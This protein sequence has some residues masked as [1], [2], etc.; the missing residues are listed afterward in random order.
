MQTGVESKSS[1]RSSLDNGFILAPYTAPII[2]LAKSKIGSNKTTV[3]YSSKGTPKALV[4]DGATLV[5]ALQDSL[6]G[7]LL[8]VTKYC[9]SVICC[10][11]TP[12]QKVF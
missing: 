8:E 9:K 12:L 2:K 10:R 6:K 1:S 11:A 5:F 3:D 7:L 4:I